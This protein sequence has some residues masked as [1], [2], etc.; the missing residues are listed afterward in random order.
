MTLALLSGTTLEGG[1][2]NDGAREIVERCAQYLKE[3]GIPKSWAE[4]C[5]VVADTSRKLA[6]DGAISFRYPDHR[7]EPTDDA[8]SRLFGADHRFH[9]HFDGVRLYMP[10]L[11]HS[12]L[13]TATVLSDARHDLVIA[14]GETRSL[15]LGYHGIATVAIG[16]I[17][18]WGSHGN[19][20]PDL[21][22]IPM[23]GRKITYVFDADVRNRKDLQ[24]PV[25][26]LAR[27]LQERGAVVRLLPMP[28]LGDGVTGAD[29]YVA[30]HGIGAF[31]KL[32]KQAKPPEHPDFASW[33]YDGVDID[34]TLVPVG[35]EWLRDKPPD[36]EWTVGD[37][38]PRGAVGLLIAQGGAGKT[39]FAQRLA[40]CVAGGRAFLGRAV[41]QGKVVHIAC[42]EREDELRRRQF[43]THRTER[44]EM[45]AEKCNDAAI[46]RF[47]RNVAEHLY[48]KS[49]VGQELYLVSMD[50]QNV[51]QGRAL[52]VLIHQLRAL[53]GVELVI[54]DPLS[55]VHSVPDESQSWG[56]AVINACER[57][58]REVGCT[59][60]VT[61]HTGKGSE[62]E[63]LYAARGAS[64]LA[65]AAR[66]V[67]LLK[68]ATPKD[69][70]GFES[71]INLQAEAAG[72]RVLRL[73]N[74]KL[75]YGPRQRDQWLFREDGVL[76]P[77]TPRRKNENEN[78]NGSERSHVALRTWFAAHPEPLFKETVR[79][80]HKA[81][82][83][84]SVSRARAV[85]L[86][87]E[88]VKCGVLV[89][90]SGAKNP[91][92]VGYV[93]ST[94]RAA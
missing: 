62:R 91:R 90:A 4:S 94:E 55:R 48:V 43:R 37:Y 46:A 61:H 9:Q 11:R 28:D 6:P 19:L 33:G 57:V 74:P 52:D 84:G 7:G 32:L 79:S 21:Q 26:A 81:I 49:V 78:E 54:I 40:Q 3:R 58:A 23:Q 38:L 17:D 68:E 29:D 30:K 80:K 10:P 14:E 75:S 50:G 69:V 35:S 42:E 5:A 44:E 77:F 56:T 88:A 59:V 85:K 16:G 1:P 63:D 83:G 72:G 53:D 92:G 66:V 45:R 8:R 47:T 51:V 76:I 12:N 60:L 25:L 89:E 65:D 36:L 41:R 39:F 13:T 18:M 86:F 82:F 64:A 67:L 87:E 15:V 2:L 31:R 20:C 93:L 73:I 70:E 71:N 27:K 22:R 24:R 34:L